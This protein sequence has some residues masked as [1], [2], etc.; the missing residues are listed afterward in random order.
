MK[1]VVLLALMFQVCLVM[2]VG[3]HHDN[4]S[5]HGR[6]REGGRH[7]DPLGKRGNYRRRKSECAK[8]KECFNA[9]KS[10]CRDG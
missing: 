8:R 7:R 3:G 9:C 5:E 2:S 6:G 10:D 4:P 1:A